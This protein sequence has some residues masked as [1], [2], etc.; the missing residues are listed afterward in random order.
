M[1]DEL[2]LSESV[3]GEEDPGAA[4][5]QPATTASPGQPPATPDSGKGSG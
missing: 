5:D 1:S 3:A 4:L 2:D